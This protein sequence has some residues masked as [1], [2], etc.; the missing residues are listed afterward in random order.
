MTKYSWLG[1]SDS[2]FFL[3]N[4]KVSHASSNN[5]SFIFPDQ[6]GIFLL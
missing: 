6:Q 1:P 5:A 2:Y 4:S 3:E